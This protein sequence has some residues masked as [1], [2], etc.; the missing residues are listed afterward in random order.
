MSTFSIVSGWW[1]PWKMAAFMSRSCRG[2]G[3][4]G[5][6]PTIPRLS[7]HAPAI[8]RKSA[9]SSRRLGRELLQEL[10]VAGWATLLPRLE[11]R[12]A[13]DRDI[14]EAAELADVGGRLDPEADRERQRGRPATL[15]DQR[16]HALREIRLLARHALS[17]DAVDEA[18]RLPADLREARRRVRGGHEEDRI[19]ILGACRRVER[20]GLLGGEIRDDEA[21]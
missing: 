16:L 6:A 2:G 4:F 12:R 13:D 20:P 17:G 5:Q 18:R 9:A 1:G 21:S 11:A 15:G 7:S 8:H 19:E 3:G 10:A 14:G